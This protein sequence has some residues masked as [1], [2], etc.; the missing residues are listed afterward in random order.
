[1]DLSTPLAWND[2]VLLLPVAELPEELRSK[3][4]CAPEDFALSRPQARSGS[5]ILDADAAELVRRFREPRTVV[6]AVILFGRAR[7][8]DPEQVLEGAFPLLKGLVQSRFLVPAEEERAAAAGQGLAARWEPGDRLL[9]ASVVR[10]LQVLEDT[11]VYLLERPGGRRS[12]AKV[13]RRLAAAAGGTGARLRRE[14]AFLAH[15]DGAGAPRLLRLDTVDD[16]VCLEL[17]LVAGVDA[18]EAAAEWR[19]RGD[20]ASRR[21]LLALCRSVAEAYAGLHARGVLHGDVHPRNVLVEGDGSVKL[22]DFGVGTAALPESGLPVTRERGGIP[23]FF[24]PELARAYAAG[25]HPPPASAAG[26]QHAVGV[27]LYVLATG[28]QPQDFSLG[29]EEML[30]ELATGKPLPFA[31]RGATPWPALEDVLYRALAKHPEDR[32]ASMAELAAAVAKVEPPPVVPRKALTETPA[33]ATGPELDR[34][35]ERAVSQAALDGPWMR[36][37]LQPAP[38]A[39]INYGAAGIGLGMLE[40]AL[41]RGDSGLLSMADLWARRAARDIGRDSGFYNPEI[42]ISREIVGE[43]SPYHSASGIHALSALVARAAHDQASQAEALG[44]FLVAVEQPAA[45]LDLTLGRSSTLLGAAILLD[46]VPARSFDPSPLRAFGDGVVGDLW[47]QLD[48]KPAIPEADV[49][50]LGIAH[51]WAG[52]LYATLV[53]CEV[54]GHPI[55]AGVERRL[56]ELAELAVPSGRGLQWPWTL[57]GGG[58]FMPGWCNGAC[59]YVFLWTLAHRLLG[60][61]R[62]LGL[63]AGAAFESWDSPQPGGTL[64]CGLAGRSYALLNLYRT[65]GDGLWLARARDLARRAAK[66]SPTQEDYPHS[67]W[68]GEL[69]LAVLAAGLER[70]EAARMPMFEPLGYGGK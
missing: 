6:E 68:K 34:L 26:E 24:E 37:G 52:F 2:D 17:E 40:M 20:G 15:L 65:T 48:A 4:D 66:G 62:Y 18:G 3:L 8:L 32:F 10:V 22:I 63:A 58:G 56:A 30:A 45:G 70:P 64:C 57:A 27:L 69:G 41:A 11:E 14:A 35:V 38:T 19:L 60:E 42:D 28:A 47:R 9:E 21:H 23:F 44:R 59:G 16:L 61:P 55:P 39:S 36:D 46:V 53:W 67:L 54:S 1:M 13:E 7:G 33:L 49:E 31:K 51:G 12:V 29:R 25:R 50:Y 5:K 43:C